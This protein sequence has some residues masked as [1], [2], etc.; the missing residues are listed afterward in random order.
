V[1]AASA[2]FAVATGVLVFW[3][4]R[5]DWDMFTIGFRTGSPRWFLIM[6]CA[7]LACMLG[8]LALGLGANSAGQRRNDKQKQ[9]WIGFFVGAFA[10]TL[11]IVFMTIFMLRGEGA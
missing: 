4:G 6:G 1:S 10:M 2:I 11:T 9:S 7:G 5:V 8:L 3:P